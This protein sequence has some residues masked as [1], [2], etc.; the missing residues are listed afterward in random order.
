MFK[1]KFKN[2]LITKPSADDSSRSKN[3]VQPATEIAKKLAP[4]KFLKILDSSVTKVSPPT[5]TSA[6]ESE[7]KKRLYAQTLDLSPYQDIVNIGNLIPD[8]ISLTDFIPGYVS[9]QGNESKSTSANDLLNIQ[10]GLRQ[11]SEDTVNRILNKL[12][13]DLDL[14]EIINEKRTTF[15]QNIDTAFKKL[16][17]Y[18]QLHGFISNYKN[19]IDFKNYKVSFKSSNQYKA[20]YT[21]TVE[22]YFKQEYGYSDLAIKSFLNTKMILQ[23]LQ[24]LY[25]SAKFYSYNSVI[26]DKKVD[27]KSDRNHFSITKEGK[28]DISKGIVG[29]NQTALSYNT[30]ISNLPSFNKSDAIFLAT[31]FLGREFKASAAINNQLFLNLLAASGIDYAGPGDDL[32]L[33]IIGVPYAVNLAMSVN[34]GSI[35]SGVK[36]ATET[37]EFVMPFENKLFVSQNSQPA[38]F[39]PGDSYAFANIMVPELSSAERTE[40]LRTF[41]SRTAFSLHRTLLK[42]VLGGFD[43][44][45]S[46]VKEEDFVSINE[47]NGKP[48]IKNKGFDEISIFDEIVK[49]IKGI[50]VSS[51]PFSATYGE[52]KIFQGT[53]DQYIIALFN[54]ARKDQS[55]KVKLEKVLRPNFVPVN[56]G[57]PYFIKPSFNITDANYQRLILIARDLFKT[58]SGIPDSLKSKIENQEDIKL[59]IDMFFNDSGYYGI[60]NSIIAKLYNSVQNILAAMLEAGAVD[61][62]ADNSIE[63]KFRNVS[64]ESIWSLVYETFFNI[65][66]TLFSGINFELYHY[67]NKYKLGEIFQHFLINSYD[68]KPIKS[69]VENIDN[70]VVDPILNSDEQGTMV[71]K[72]N[73]ILYDGVNK[74]RDVRNTLI[75][76]KVSLIKSLQILDFFEQFRSYINDI[77]NFISNTDNL[78]FIRDTKQLIID[79]TDKQSNTN[80]DLMHFNQQQIVVS[81]KRL[82]DFLDLINGTKLSLKW[83]NGKAVPSESTAPP[84][85]KS[86]IGSNEY[87]KLFKTWL[88]TDYTAKTVDTNSKILTVGIPYSLSDN[89]KEKVE[90]DDDTNLTG[91]IKDVGISKGELDIIKITV[92]KEDLEYEDIIFKPKQYIF[93]LSRFV[94]RDAINSETALG[95][96]IAGNKFYTN[97]NFKANPS[98]VRDTALTYDAAYPNPIPP[99][100]NIGSEFNLDIKNQLNTN[101]L[102]ELKTNHVNSDMLMLY[103]KLLIGADLQEVNFPVVDNIVYPVP[104]QDLLELFNLLGDEEDLQ[105]WAQLF[106]TKT[107]L[108]DGTRE[109]LELLVPK[110]YERIFNILIDEYDFPID[111]DTTEKALL[112]T[113]EGQDL[114]EKRD[115]ELYLSRQ[116]LENISLER[117]YVKISTLTDVGTI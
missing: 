104:D 51:S 28:I 64:R 63:T 87:I 36:Y 90:L 24:E 45:S 18:S 107:V 35:V 65:V 94:N 33:K 27:R 71:L 41:E 2:L 77:N 22:E 100:G 117:F 52:N 44:T 66:T 93:E 106:T 43:Y 3:I 97:T 112:E 79:N 60:K 20:N 103:I 61:I 86:D 6:S 72:P 76:N 58:T 91:P 92:Y 9:M 25:N 75:E 50:K 15:T 96:K 30:I 37:N 109:S 1:T 99:V 4:A 114:L 78:Q 17:S 82:G 101:Q 83:K 67:A 21:F 69:L 85:Y 46:T 113:L 31:L 115:G 40:R 32:F 11:L 95:K 29:S 84:I 13:D 39:T 80:V 26:S 42:M 57:S 53:M 89:L 81:R 55:L 59:F 68:G 7:A 88:N 62:T 49:S 98:D 105:T 5:M 34:D 47:A 23:F 14:A 56:Q 48:V 12:Y 38:G 54:A 74:L 102:R 111:K 116:K 108:T 70:I 73:R 110:K 10:I 16:S 8:I 19:I